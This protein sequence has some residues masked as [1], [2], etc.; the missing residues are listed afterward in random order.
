MLHQN[1]VSLL[2]V[3]NVVRKVVSA[4]KHGNRTASLADNDEDQASVIDPAKCLV[5]GEKVI[6]DQELDQ[7]SSMCSVIVGT[8]INEIG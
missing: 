3:D 4:R 7:C 5:R 1:M 2:V 6:L 8:V